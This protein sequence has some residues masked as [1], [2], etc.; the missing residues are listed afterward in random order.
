MCS[1]EPQD[2]DEELHSVS[3]SVIAKTDQNQNEDGRRTGRSTSMT[4]FSSLTRKS[5]SAVK[6]TSP[7]KRT[8]S[9]TLS[10]SR[11][12]P[13]SSRL[14]SSDWDLCQQGR[15]TC[16]GD[17]TPEQRRPHQPTNL[18][19]PDLVISPSKSAECLDSS[20]DSSILI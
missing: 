20:G 10:P 14:N 2:R 13:E 17:L 12:T 6:I 19:L 3:A 5:G 18:P 16:L 1:M 4:W 8:F 11:R 7:K 9:N 15:Q